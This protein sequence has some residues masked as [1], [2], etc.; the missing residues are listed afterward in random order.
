M[1]KL[2]FVATCCRVW[3]DAPDVAGPR[4]G[5]RQV[6]FRATAK[7]CG[8]DSRHLKSSLT[9]SFCPS[10]DKAWLIPF[11]VTTNRK[12]MEVNGGC[13]SESFVLKGYSAECYF[14]TTPCPAEPRIH[15]HFHG[16]QAGLNNALV[17]LKLPLLRP[18]MPSPESVTQR[19]FAWHLHLDK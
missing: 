2:H 12:Q 6:P 10:P 18:K 11:Q 1:R 17:R 16:P 15:N 4:I 8:E 19:E 3:F 7:T 5:S 14:A 9:S 13:P